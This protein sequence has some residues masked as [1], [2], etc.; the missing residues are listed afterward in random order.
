[1]LEDFFL[2]AFIALKELNK[3][4]ICVHSIRFHSLVQHASN[5]SLRSINK[6][7]GL[8]STLG[9]YSYR[10]KEVNGLQLSDLLLIIMSEMY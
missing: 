6:C 9:L 7:A 4:V 2:L 5:L 1:M 8:S 10:Y 3:N